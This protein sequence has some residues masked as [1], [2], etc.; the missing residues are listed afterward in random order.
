[1]M[2]NHSY[3]TD[4]CTFELLSAYLD[5][6]VTPQQRQEVQDLLANDADIQGLYRRLLALRQEIN[7]LPIP[8][9]QHNSRQVA[10]SVFHKIDQ[11]KKQKKRLMIGGGAIAIAALATLAG[12]FTNNRNPLLQIAQQQGDSENLELS[13]AESL[14]AFGE[15]YHELSTTEEPLALPVSQSLFYEI[16]QP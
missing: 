2:S 4:K 6:E 1:M 11:E 15:P 8:Q 10:Q 13:L 5:G 12:L 16:N 3:P 14:L 9:P 7:N